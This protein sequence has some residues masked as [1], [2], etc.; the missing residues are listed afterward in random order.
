MR[1]SVEVIEMVIGLPPEVVIIAVEVVDVEFAAACS[2][3]ICLMPL[4]GGHSDLMVIGGF[5]LVF[6]ELACVTYFESDTIVGVS[7]TRTG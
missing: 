5:M 7:A 1:F 2:R 3:F 6:Q 4:A